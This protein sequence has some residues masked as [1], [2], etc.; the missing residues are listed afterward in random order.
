L[1]QLISLQRVINFHPYEKA[2]NAIDLSINSHL[3]KDSFDDGLI[4]NMLDE[5]DRLI[6][7]YNTAII[8]SKS[9]KFFPFQLTFDESICTDENGIQIFAPSANATVIDYKVQDL[10]LATIK[11]KRE[12]LD[13]YFEVAKDRKEI[14]EHK[15]SIEKIKDNIKS[16]EKKSYELVGLFAALI[17]FLF[18]T[19]NIFTA[20]NTSLPQLLVNTSG[21]GIILLLFLSV[22]VSTSPFFVEK[23]LNLTEYFK[24]KRFYIPFVLVLIHAC[25]IIF[26]TFNLKDNQNKIHASNTKLNVIKS[27]VNDSLATDGKYKV[28]GVKKQVSTTD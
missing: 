15:T 8:W 11:Q 22:F 2:I 7:K 25:L 6:K 20:S 5:L 23:D 18:G 9:H 16:S 13:Y 28:K 14:E 1:V 27:H 21:L 26:L 19:I 3:K 24:T 10:H 4:Q 12:L 17:T